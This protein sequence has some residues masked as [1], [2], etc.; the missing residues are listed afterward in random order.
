RDQSGLL[1]IA[2]WGG[3]LQRYH[4]A[5]SAFRVVRHRPA[6]TRGLSHADVRSVLELA[7]RR[8]L[9][10]TGGNG[11]DIFE[12]KQGLT[13]GW[14]AQPGQRGGL[15]DGNIMALLEQADGTLWAG[16]QQAGVVR[17]PPGSD[18]WQAFGVAEGLPA[19]LVRTLFQS[20][21]GS[22]WV[23]GTNGMARWE[24]GT[25]R[26]VTA[27]QRDGRVLQADVLALAEDR[28]GN[29]WAA[30]DQGLWRQSA[31]SADWE[32][33][34]HQP[35]QPNSLSGNNLQSLLIDGAGVLWVSGTKG[36]DRLNG[37]VAGAPVFEH[38]RSKLLHSNDEIGS[39]LWQDRQGRIWIGAAEQAL[40]PL[41]LKTSRNGL[42]DL[43]ASWI[44]AWSSSHDGLLL[45]GGVQGLAIFDPSRFRPWTFQGPVRVSELKIDGHA[46]PAA[47]RQGLRLQ[48]EQRNFSVEFSALDFF[49]P[50]AI[51]YRYRLQGYDRDWIDSD[52]EHRVAAYGNLWPGKYV[53]QIQSTNSVGDWNPQP[54]AIPVQVLPALWQNWWFM[55]LAALSIL[56]AIRALHQ[57]RVARLKAQH[58][59]QAEQLRAMVEQRTS[60][61]VCAHNAL[62]AAHTELSQSHQSLQQTQQ[63]LILQE[64][65]AGLGTLTA[66]IAHEINNPLNFTHV[67]AQIQRD[68]VNEFE[69]FVQ[70]LFDADTDPR[71]VAGFSHRFAEL[72][73]NLDIMQDGTDRINAVVRDLRA[74]TRL[75]EA[76][77]KTVQLS[78][79]LAATVNLVR[80]QW[81]DQVDF[82]T[83]WL[84]DPPYECWP[85]LLN[86]VFMNLVLNACQAIAAKQ[87]QQGSKARGRVNIKL[88]Q[89]AQHLC[90]TIEDDGIGMSEQL[91]KRIMEPFF[92]TRD[93][94]S[95]AGM[96]LAVSYGIIQKHG[97][98]LEISTAVGSG[99]RFTIHLPLQ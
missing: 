14:R 29:L 35:A 55:L 91:Q 73:Q 48:P 6:H 54:L 23:A 50:G 21:T 66:G 49:K 18:Q 64:K 30:S 62:A 94:G 83:E 88:Q 24:P 8:I 67:A 97:G 16:T 79:S 27:R 85:A 38:V 80:T 87:H 81:Q 13:G 52:P 31:G 41:T 56:A 69:Q 2:T 53:L 26:F 3:G 15:P 40:D 22:L 43:G 37:F 57:L 78:Q 86:Q 60:E 75:D 63:Q 89:Q 82:V 77:C 44:G 72:H 39:D 76:E 59:E 28:Q 25:A 36:L 58:H 7:D 34:V 96:G 93:V 19:P 68:K 65:M 46:V 92:T 74:F 42:P 47:L 5:Q 32:N 12:R 95:G 33:F 84:D 17:L 99:S 71:V 90:V 51:R 20:R 70:S 98:T 1:W 61:I 9:V 10:G 11:I 4:P 45:Y